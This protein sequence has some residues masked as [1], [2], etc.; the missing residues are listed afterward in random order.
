MMRLIA[1]FI[2]LVIA[3]TSGALA[4]YWYPN[5]LGS[6]IP[7]RAGSLSTCPASVAGP[8]VLPYMQTVDGTGAALGVSGNPFY[9]IG[10]ITISGTPTVVIGSL[11]LP[12]NAA[13]E[14]GGN[15]AA[16]A[17]SLAGTLAQQQIGTANFATAQISVGTSATLIVAARSGGRGTGRKTTCI[18]NTSTTAVYLGGS[19][20]TTSTGD[21]LAAGAGTGK[22][23]DTQAA[24]Y[25]IVASGS[26]TVTETETY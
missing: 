20:V 17:S 7:I 2:V 24:I 11:P 19:G 26:E 1:A 3:S 10:S 23:F 14:T 16:I 12:P 15:L 25:G 9:V 6:P 18:T 5:P 8:C 4:D 13:Q 21:L 22:C